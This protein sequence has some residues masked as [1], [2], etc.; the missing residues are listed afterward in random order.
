MERAHTP[1]NNCCLIC[2]GPVEPSTYT[3]LAFIPKFWGAHPLAGSFKCWSGRCGVQTL[4]SSGRTESWGFTS[5]CMVLCWEVG[6][7][8]RVYVSQ[9]FL[10]I[11]VWIFSHLPY[12]WE[13][14]S[15]FWISPQRNCSMTAVNLTHLWE[16]ENL[17]SCYIVILVERPTVLIM[18]A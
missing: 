13:L 9:P 12:E 5:H 18:S 2:C 17:G 16:E 7:M 3:P 15:S 1:M 11:A 6:F 4:H 14:L 10:P 8:A